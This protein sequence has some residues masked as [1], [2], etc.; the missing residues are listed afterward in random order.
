MNIEH[1]EHKAQIAKIMIVRAFVYMTAQTSITFPVACGGAAG[2][3]GA[4]C[5]RRNPI[6]TIVHAV[7]VGSIST[8]GINSA[9]NVGRNSG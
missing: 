2:G 5:F 7:H 3:G 9:T 1:D 8:T 4:L 6:T